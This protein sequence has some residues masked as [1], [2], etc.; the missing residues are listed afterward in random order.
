MASIGNTIFEIRQDTCSGNLLGEKE[1]VC[2]KMLEFGASKSYY[3]NKM[4]MSAA[5]VQDI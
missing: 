1:K 2:C 4:A 3:G 5:M